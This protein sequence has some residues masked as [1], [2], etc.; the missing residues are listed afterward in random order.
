MCSLLLGD[1]SFNFYLFLL[2]N[3][4]KCEDFDFDIV[5]FPF[6]DGDVSRRASYTFRNLLGFLESAIM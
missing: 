2:K 6:L 3:Y 1:L 4:D 5:N